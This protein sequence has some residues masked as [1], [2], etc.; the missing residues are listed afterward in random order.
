MPSTAPE[1]TAKLAPMLARWLIRATLA[2]AA[3]PAHAALFDD[4]VARAQALAATPFA[5]QPRPAVK[6][7]SD[8]LT[9]DQ[10]RDIRFRPDRSL[11]RKDGLPFEVQ[12]FHPGFVNT[13]TVKI[14][15]VDGAT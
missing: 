2:L 4:V 13:E 15:E 7:A 12:F 8:S 6:A 11:W 5:P 14:N 1:T 10:Y 9:Y 3:V